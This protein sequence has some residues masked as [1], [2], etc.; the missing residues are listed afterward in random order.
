MDHS[1]SEHDRVPNPTKVI[2]FPKTDILV[3]SQTNITQEYIEYFKDGLPSNFIEVSP[4]IFF[5][6]PDNPTLVAK[7]RIMRAK[8]V[9]RKRHEG[10]YIRM[11]QESMNAGNSLMNEFSLVEEIQQ[12][13]NSEEAQQF[14]KEKGFEGLAYVRPIIGIINRENGKKYMVYPFIEG[15]QWY[16]SPPGMIIEDHE[17]VQ[18]LINLFEE[19][20][21]NPED[22]IPRQFRIGP[23]N[24][25]YLLDTDQY[26]KVP[27]RP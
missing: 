2:H 22:L 16:T 26:H 17:P 24:W 20:G 15:K 25:M 3:P 21:I 8:D 14:A 18:P 4:E 19:K 12:V 11:T 7:Q 23:D 6:S 10:G 13:V 1:N 5:N 9:R 27:N